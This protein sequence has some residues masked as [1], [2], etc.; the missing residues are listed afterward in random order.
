MK[1]NLLKFCGNKIEKSNELIFG[2]FGPFETTV[3]LGSS[4]LL[5]P[6]R[7]IPQNQGKTEVL[8]V[9]PTT[10][11]LLIADAAACCCWIDLIYSVDMR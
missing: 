6:Q 4:P 9:L 8:P 2:G 10:A 1:V 11:T 5:P 3:Q 7:S